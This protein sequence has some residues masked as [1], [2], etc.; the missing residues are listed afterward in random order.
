MSIGQAKILES[1]RERGGWRWGARR[2]NQ[3]DEGKGSF[4]ALHTIFF[5]GAP[6]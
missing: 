6:F 1:S 2:E 5:L 3:E 4:L